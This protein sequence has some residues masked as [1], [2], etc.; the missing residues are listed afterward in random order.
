[1]MT[2]VEIVSR[3]IKIATKANN[4]ALVMEIRQ[5]INVSMLPFDEIVRRRGLKEMVASDTQG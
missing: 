1:M 5:D 2:D 4:K 3:A